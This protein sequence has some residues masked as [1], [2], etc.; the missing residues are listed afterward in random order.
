MREGTAGPYRVRPGKRVKL[1][2][3]DPRDVHLLEDG[4]SQA[5]EENARIRTRIAELQEMLFAGHERKLLIVLQ[6]MDTS[7]KDGTIRHVM[8]GFNPQGT[9]I[10]SFGKPTEVELDHDYLWRV[11]RQVPGKGEVVVFNRSHYED[12][13]VVRVHGLVPKAV[14][15]KRYA[16]INAFEEMLAESGTT[17]LKF[18]LHISRNEQK[19]R[20]QARIDD[21]SKRWKF[22]LGDLEERKLWDEYQQAYEDALSKTATEHAPWYVVPADQKWYRNYVVGS[23]VV[24]ALESMNLAY[25]QPDLSRILVDAPDGRL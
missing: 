23:V 12:V 25:P 22:Q 17:I 15:R 5:K 2:E 10:A 13:L 19:A 21:P 18:F 14:W 4:K 11:H 7:G 6:G 16:Q 9:R 3:I 24:E 8:A 20:L 1:E